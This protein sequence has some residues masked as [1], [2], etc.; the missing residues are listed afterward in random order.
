MELAAIDWRNDTFLEEK[1]IR[2][3]RELENSMFEEIRND[4]IALINQTYSLARRYMTIPFI[5]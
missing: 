3:F 2:I 4:N 5:N 1:N